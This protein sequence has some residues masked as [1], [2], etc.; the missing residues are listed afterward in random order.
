MVK[1][2]VYI[3][4]TKVPVYKTLLWIV[5]SDSLDRSIDTVEDMIDKRVMDPE[6]RKSTLAYTYAYTKSDGKYHLML[7]LHPRQ[8][9]GTIAH[10][11]FHITNIV[12]SWHGVR[13][14]HSND[15][16]HA[17]FLDWMVEQCHAAIEQY[18]KKI[19]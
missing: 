9:H 1:N 7:F 10:E 8:R 14:S 3:K 13:P 2:R 18:R 19:S 4:K 11:A 6:E 15:E 17:Y 12:Y 5:I 16:A